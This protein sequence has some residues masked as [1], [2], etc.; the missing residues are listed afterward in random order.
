MTER[1]ICDYWRCEWTGT[2]DQALS[3]PDPF[4]EGS[5]LYACPN[6]RDMTLVRAC[7]VPGCKRAAS[8]G[9]PTPD[10]YRNT[11]GEHRPK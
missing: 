5:T 3:A 9:T 7:D 8:C 4:N 2:T 10:G 1:L 11:C 6:C